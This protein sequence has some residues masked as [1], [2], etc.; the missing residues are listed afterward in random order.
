MK[1]ASFSPTWCAVR[2]LW[3]NR[4]VVRQQAAR[5]RQEA[6][7]VTAELAVVLPA[8]IL[9]LVCCLGAVQTVGQQLRLTDTVADAARSLGRGDS[10]AEARSLARTLAGETAFS[11]EQDGQFVCVRLSAPSIFAPYASLGLTVTA[12]SCALTGGL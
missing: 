5:A 7:T 3:G 10:P 12:R 2:S 8:V 1:C 6:G 4:R 11:S 9:V